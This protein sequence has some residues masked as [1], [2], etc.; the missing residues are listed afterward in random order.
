MKKYIK[1]LTIFEAAKRLNLSTQSV[2]LKLRAGK[3]PGARQVG[4]RNKWEIPEE[5]LR[6]Y[7]ESCRREAL[8][9]FPDPVEHAP[10]LI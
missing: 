4:V 9:R 8:A 3:F 1:Y 5:S 6:L 10:P 7:V 2:Y